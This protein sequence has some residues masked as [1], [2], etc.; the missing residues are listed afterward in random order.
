MFQKNSFLTLNWQKGPK[1]GSKV[2]LFFAFFQKNS[3]MKNMKTLCFTV[4]IFDLGKFWFRIFLHSNTH[5]RKVAYKQTKLAWRCPTI[6]S[7][8]KTCLDIPG[9][10]LVLEVF[11]DNHH[12]E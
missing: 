9:V 10:P 7:H 12:S 2:K 8:D 11:L 5:Q 3:R 4:Q 6:P 1:M